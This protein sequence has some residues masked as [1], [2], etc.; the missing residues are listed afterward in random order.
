MA[1]IQAPQVGPL[2]RSHS[3]ATVQEALISS[4]PASLRLRLRREV[5][6]WVVEK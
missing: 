1:G 3:Q 2:A 5:V 4:A 6:E